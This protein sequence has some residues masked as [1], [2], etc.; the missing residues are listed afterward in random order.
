M[1]LFDYSALL[2]SGLVTYGPG[3]IFWVAVIIL[4]SISRRRGGGRAERFI[5]IGASIKII[6]NLL[7]FPAGV[8]PLWLRAAGNDLDAI[9]AITSGYGIFLNVISMAGIICLLYGFWVQFREKNIAAAPE[10]AV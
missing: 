9:T 3:L 8:M 7:S 5:I 4:A 1:G 6:G 10:A 2:I